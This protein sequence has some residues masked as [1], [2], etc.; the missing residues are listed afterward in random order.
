MWFAVLLT[1]TA[2]A[3]ISIGKV[4]TLLSTSLSAQHYLDYS[5][6]N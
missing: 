3:A 4:G 6:V 2:S 5:T 1:L